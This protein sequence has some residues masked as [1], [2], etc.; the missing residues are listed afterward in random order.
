MSTAAE[1]LSQEM[2]TIEFRM[3]ATRAELAETTHY[4]RKNRLKTN[5]IEDEK[6]LSRLATE[7]GSKLQEKI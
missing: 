6:E 4:R 5:L 1:I 3:E 2:R 7:L